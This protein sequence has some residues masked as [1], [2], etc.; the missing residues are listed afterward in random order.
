[1]VGHIRHELG[2]FYESILVDAT[3][4]RDAFRALFGDEREDY[5]EAMDRH[6]AQGAAARLGA[7]ATSAPTRRCT[8]G[9]T[10]PRR[11][12]T[13]CTSA[14]RSRPRARSA[15]SSPGR[16]RP[17]TPASW[18]SRPSSTRDDPFAEIIDNW[19]P[20]TYALNAVNRSMGLEDLYPFIARPDGH[21]QAVVHPRP[22]RRALMLVPHAPGAGHRGRLGDGAAA[23]LEAPARDRGPPLPD[24]RRDPRGRR[25]GRSSATPT[26]PR[27]TR[28]RPGRRTS[29]RRSGRAARAR[30]ARR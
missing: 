20:L 17:R 15:C 12:P 14:R 28:S 9:R 4:A 13:T 25:G 18:R 5:S 2:H 16:R 21:R 3:G 23:A 19:L 27:R 11:S 22:G 29:P 7:G 30:R 1:M 10:G 6:Y 26:S 24:D 8:R